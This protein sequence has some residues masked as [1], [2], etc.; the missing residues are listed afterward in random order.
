MRKSLEWVQRINNL[1]LRKL[2][3]FLLN[4]PLLWLKWTLIPYKI[5]CILCQV[6]KS[7]FENSFW[8]KFSRGNLAMWSITPV[9]EGSLW[10][11]PDI[12]APPNSRFTYHHL[13]ASSSVGDTWI[14]GSQS[15][16]LMCLMLYSV[17]HLSYRYPTL[18]CS[19]NNTNISLH[20]GLLS[21]G[22]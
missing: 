14:L 20:S 1:P 11:V 6:S 5:H 22:D 2:G 10:V 15:P 8:K 21:W 16:F 3:H 13:S 12:H 4:P 7:F 9:L 18:W 19:W 17:N